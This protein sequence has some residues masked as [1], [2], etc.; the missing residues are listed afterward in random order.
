MV[1]GADAAD[2]QSYYADADGD[3]FGDESSL[4]VTCDVL[5][6]VV[7]EAGDCDDGDGD[8]NPDAEEVCNDGVD[9]NCIADDACF[10]DLTDADVE[11]YGIDA[12]DQAG[13]SADGAGDINNDGYADLIIGGW[14]NDEG[15]TDAG[16]AYLAYG[17]ITSGD[18]TLDE[19]S[20][21]ALTGFAIIGEESTQA[22]G[23]SVAGVGD[24]DGDGRDDFIVSA[25]LWDEGATDA[26]GAA[27]FL[28]NSVGTADQSFTDADLLLAGES[29]TDYAGGYLNRGGDTNNDGYMD[30]LVGAINDD[31]GGGNAGAVYL[32]LGSSSIGG[33]QS[34]GDSEAKFTAEAASDKAG[35]AMDT[36]GDLNGDGND[37]VVIGVRL[38]DPGDVTDA[39]TSYLMLGPATG[40]ISMGDAEAAIYGDV[41]SDRFGETV[42]STGDHNGDS[43]DDVLIAATLEDTGGSQA[44]AVYLIQGTATVSSLDGLGAG[45]AMSIMF[46][47]GS[48]SEAIGNSLAGGSDL[49]G[50]GELDFVI[51]GASAGI[52]SEGEAYVFFG[53][54]T[55]GSYSTADADATLAGD[56]NS[57]AAGNLVRIAGDVN[58]TGT[59]ALLVGAR[60][61]DANGTDAGAV[62]LLHDLGL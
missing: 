18:Y 12:E 1:D 9:N 36:A 48:S 55:S 58:G 40:S 6:D 57:D 21:G 54:L 7:L 24:V 44:G 47:G 31:D 33:E 15:D 38:T 45:S 22:V 19:V 51:G 37:D 62:Y 30:F 2:A 27:L 46:Y 59:D 43:Y 42:A 56:T 20:G 4:Q 60:E 34:L 53:P 61:D 5:D 49:N 25:T 26:G 28:G 32:I 10:M 8:I 14:R 16:A 11:F 41:S 29:K 35:L 13:Y 39:G 50:D 23:R 3:G 17:P 52:S